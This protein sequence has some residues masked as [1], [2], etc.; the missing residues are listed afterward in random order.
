M[1][2]VIEG[3]ENPGML[4]EMGDRHTV[5]LWKGTTLGSLKELFTK[6]FLMFNGIR[7]EKLKTW[8]QGGSAL[9]HLGDKGTFLDYNVANGTKQDPVLIMASTGWPEYVRRYNN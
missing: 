9:E 4:E 6:L 7:P 1:V 8:V 5:A 3:G 2:M